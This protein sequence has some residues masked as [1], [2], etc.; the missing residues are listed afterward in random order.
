M[1]K[2]NKKYCSEKLLALTAQKDSALEFVKSKD[3]HTIPIYQKKALHSRY[4]PLK[5]SEKYTSQ[6]DSV[7][8]AIGAGGLYHLTSVA[9]QTSV[10]AI[11]V[12][13]NLTLQILEE[14][15]LDELFPNNNLKIITLEELP[16]TFPFF[17][18]SSYQIILH[19]VLSGLFAEETNRIVQWIQKNFNPQLTNIKTQKAFGK[20]WLKNTLLN[21]SNMEVFNT[22]PLNIENKVIIVCGA[23]PS[24]DLS[25]PLLQN[26]RSQLYIAAADTALPILVKN[27]ITPDSVFSMDTSPYSVYHF[28]GTFDKSIRFFKDYTSSLK[29]EN[30]SISLLFSDF[31]LLPNCGFSLDLLPRLDTSSG[32][33]GASIIQFFNNYFPELPLICT[34]IDFGFYNRIGYSK[35]NYHEIYRLHHASYFSNSEQYEAKLFYRQTPEYLQAWSRNSQNR[36][37]AVQQPLL[38]CKTLS[39][40]P[41]IPWE[42]INNNAEL[43]KIINTAKGKKGTCKLSLPDLKN[44]IEYLLKLPEKALL[45]IMT[46]YFLSENKIPNIKEAQFF[47]ETLKKEIQ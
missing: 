34:G 28:V 39:P 36:Y 18:S 24:L 11:S 5:E 26:N 19:P 15:S 44:P 27:K 16:E 47:L 45:Q 6:S 23:G 42:K 17:T 33:I 14:I 32:N 22:E 38:N 35:G 13:H 7:V 29:S 37:Y 21:L 41:F 2:E 4:F 8:I 10:I 25:L 31:P 43:E 46:P 9:K 20:K 12:C 3:S 1:K 30:N 40:S